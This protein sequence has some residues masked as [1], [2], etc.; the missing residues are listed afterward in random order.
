M[1]VTLAIDTV[2][3]RGSV[4]LGV[5]GS[6]REC[7][8]LPN[9]EHARTLLPRSLELLQR[10]AMAVADL[11]EII[12]ADGPGSF[13][14][15]RIGLATASG[16]MRQRPRVKLLTASSLLAA[17]HRAAELGSP[18]AAIY[19]AL[20]GEVFAAIYDFSGGQLTT[21][22]EPTLMTFDALRKGPTSAATVTGD[23]TDTYAAAI[24]DWTGRPA[25]GEKFRNCFATS[26]IELA[27]FPGALRYIENLRTFEPAYGRLAEAQVRWE[28][29]HERKLPSSRN[30]TV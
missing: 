1:R 8:E 9:R 10:N 19:D 12:V 5:D 25:A 4:A 23:C 11:T 20:R 13:T 7:A 29:L 27:E 17:A 26:L 2:A 30:P 21:L 3:G 28:K 16:V 6:V 15:I 22:L 14:G 18:V 24:E